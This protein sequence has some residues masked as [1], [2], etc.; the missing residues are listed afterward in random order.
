KPRPRGS[1][2][3]RKS[4]PVWNH[5]SARKNTGLCWRSFRTRAGD[6]VGAGRWPLFRGEPLAGH[7]GAC[8]PSG[9]T[10]LAFLPS[11]SGPGERLRTA[12]NCHS[13]LGVPGIPEPAQVPAGGPSTA[14]AR[15]CGQPPGLL[16][17]QP[18]QS[19]LAFPP[20]H[21]RPTTIDPPPPPGNMRP[22]PGRVE[23]PVPRNTGPGQ[24]PG[25]LSLPGLAPSAPP[26]Q[27][28]SPT[29]ASAASQELPPWSAWRLNADPRPRA[30]PGC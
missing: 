8:L 16:W 24:R 6:G 14:H 11:R 2:R 27:R 1:C 23:T 25:L 26:L 13:F 3:T 18:G 15:V 7:G 29:R 5:P 20:P 21:P 12:E 10:R 22:S 9:L 30:H 28:R 4:P 17:E 19:S